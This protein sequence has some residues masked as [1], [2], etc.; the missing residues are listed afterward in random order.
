MSEAVAQ[1]SPT[2][3]GLFPRLGSALAIA[4]LGVWTAWHLWENLYAWRGGE[5]W[6]ERVVSTAITAQGPQYTGNP[7][8]STLVSILV[9]APLLIH[10]VW[11]VRRI[12]MAKPNG[13]AFFGNATYLLQRVSALGVLAFL[14]AHVYLARISPALHSPTGHESFDDLAAHMAHHPPTL[15]VYIL[16]VLGTTYHLANG[17][18]TAAF[19]H[20]FA[21]SPKAQQRMRVVSVGLFLVLLG[22]GWG[23]VAGLYHFGAPLLPPV[24]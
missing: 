8:S 24:D 7:V 14:A 16:G 6:S 17:V 5:A 2:R 10:L 1:T 13:Y 20:G 22:I 12:G 18:Y 4:P 3:G 23:A 21:A 15:A 11:G 9:F 19:I